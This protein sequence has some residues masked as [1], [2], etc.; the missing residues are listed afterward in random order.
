MSGS[1]ETPKPANTRQLSELKDAKVRISGA[2]RLQV[3]FKI[4]D[5]VRKLLPGSDVAGA[6][7]SCRGC[8]GCSM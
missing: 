7:G 2:D 3:E 1:E 8:S 5:L 6:C 4:D